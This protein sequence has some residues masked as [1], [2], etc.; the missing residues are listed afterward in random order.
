LGHIHSSSPSEQVLNR[1]VITGQV[2]QAQVLRDVDDAILEL[3]NGTRTSGRGKNVLPLP[4]IQTH[5]SIPS[6]ELVRALRCNQKS[7]S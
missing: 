2:R 5:I 4:N 6:P 7:I 3:A 1:W